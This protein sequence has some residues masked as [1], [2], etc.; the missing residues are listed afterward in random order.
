MAV[1]VERLQREAGC[2]IVGP[3]EP[4]WDEARSAWNASVDQ[5]PAAVALPDHPEEV[6]GALRAA[7]AAGL[8]VAAQMTGHGAAPLGDL[9]GTLLVRT[10]GLR[11][12]AVDGA[13]RRARV[14]AGARWGEVVEAAQP[15]GLAGLAGSSPGVGVVGYTLG[16]GYGW[17]G[18][19]Y[20]LA[21]NSVLAADVVTADGRLMRVDAENEPDLFWALRGGGGGFGVVTAL[22]FELH[23]VAELSAGSLFFPIERGAE[24]LAAWLAA[25]RGQPEGVTTVGRLLRL[26]PIPDIPQP[27]RGREFA[28]VELFC[29]DGVEQAAEAAAPLRALGPEIDTLETMPAAAIGRVH[30]DPPDPVPAVGEGRLLD[31]LPD[32]AM[33][34]VAGAAGAG[35]G[36]S[37]ISLEIRPLGG[38]FARRAP[39][40]GALDAV[41]APFIWFAVGAAPG[42]P[43]RADAERSLDAAVGALAP[44]AAASP[45]STLNMLDRPVGGLSLF[46]PEVEARLRAVK[47]AYDP[48]GRL[49]SAWAEAA[50]S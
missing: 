38:A 45:N 43:A 40:G 17:L 41:E 24:V 12:V 46:R 23:P 15:H 14:A 48:D 6:A 25:T 49:R 20:G 19:R 28:L 10:A 4:G 39:D 18:R 31:D 11:G 2:R 33:A 34:A 47:A 9:E 26:P 8:R 32:D 35:S 5:R 44:W 7:A 3:D 21:C 27:L 22:E 37:L 13:A 16:G 50:G 29:L 1:S 42:P 30:M 36:S